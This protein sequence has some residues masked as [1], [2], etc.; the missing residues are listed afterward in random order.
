MPGLGFPKPL[1]RLAQEGKGRMVGDRPKLYGAVQ[2]FEVLLHRHV[3][4]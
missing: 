4:A 3:G 2:Q 1:D